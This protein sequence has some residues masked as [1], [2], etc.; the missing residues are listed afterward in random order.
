VKCV[1]GEMTVAAKSRDIINP[2]RLVATI[3]GR[4]TNGGHNLHREV[5]SLSD[6]PS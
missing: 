2:N 1:G 5:P 3:A 4:R 6:T